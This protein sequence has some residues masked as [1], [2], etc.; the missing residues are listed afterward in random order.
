[1]FISI[2]FSTL[3]LFLLSENRGLTVEAFSPRRINQR[4]VAHNPSSTSFNFGSPF[5]EIRL[6]NRRLPGAYQPNRS[7]V[8]FSQLCMASVG[9]FFGTSTGNTEEVADL[10]A[11]R[12]QEE[13]IEVAGPTNI[14]SVQGKVYKEFQKYNSLILGTP[15]W[16]TGADEERSGTEWDEI[17]Y[18]EI[19]SV[20]FSG[21]NVAVFGLGDQ[22]SYA[23][24]Y[25]DATGELY[26][27][28]QSKNCKMFGHTAIEGYEHEESKAV[29]DDKFCGLLCDGVNQQELSEKRVKNWI[30]QLLS[31]GFFEENTQSEVT[32]EPVVVI[33]KLNGKE[34]AGETIAVIEELNG[35]IEKKVPERPPV[36]VDGLEKNAQT[37]ESDFTPHFNPR[38]GKTMWISADGRMSYFS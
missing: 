5:S 15:T 22:S 16:N 35:A 7:T 6:K 2:I 34:V 24:N 28:F 11:K 36:A 17:Y 31:E 32:V 21:K 1:M 37:S 3:S 29:R 8:S 14:S 26:D 25:A 27:V 30:T 23:E 12:M 4:N 13:G 33:E 19:D 9:I 10:L 20:D 38:T 18:G